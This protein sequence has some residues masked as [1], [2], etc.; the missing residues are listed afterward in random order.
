MRPFEFHYP[1]RVLVGGDSTVLL[2]RLTSPERSTL[3]VFGRGSAERTGIARQ[4]REAFAG[5]QLAE[6]WGVDSN[7]GLDDVQGILDAIRE[8]RVTFLLAV[9]GGSVID[10]VKFAAAAARAEADPRTVLLKN[11]RPPHPIEVGALVTVA[12]TGSESNGIAAIA[13]RS[14]GLKAVYLH[15]LTRPTFAI[16]DAESLSHL[17]DAQ[18]KNGIVDAFVHVL[19]QYATYSVG[20]LVQER[21]AEALLSALLELGEQQ[22]CELTS[23]DARKNFLWAANLAQSGLLATGV[24]EDWATHFIGHELTALLGIEHARTLAL[25]LPALYRARLDGKKERL[26][27]L[28]RRVFGLSHGDDRELALATITKIEQFFQ[29]LGMSTE[30]ATLGLGEPEIARVLAG[31]KT[32]RRARLGERLDFTHDQVRALLSGGMR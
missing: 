11:I 12:G 1:T 24:P 13:D 21:L 18:L 30:L 28:G 15:P 31:L 10:A 29:S 8:H 16:L 5:R 25:V 23:E 9:G 6:H 3:A 4:V 17:S 26:A 32:T 2:K 27:Q 22:S 7:P 14:A 19:E 20:A